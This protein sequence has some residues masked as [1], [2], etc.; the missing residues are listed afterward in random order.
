M[1][2]IFAVHKL[3]KFS[4]NPSK[5]HFEGLVHLLRYISDNNNLDLKYYSYLNDAPISDLL[6][7]DSIKTENK[8][9]DFSGSRWQDFPDTRRSAEAYIIFYQ[10]GSI[11]HGTHIPVP[12]SQ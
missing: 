10:G 12:F 6:R 2:L 5:V 8:F 11:E 1:D 9:M 3:T 4:S 7:Q